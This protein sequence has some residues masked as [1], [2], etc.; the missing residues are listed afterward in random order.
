MT[1]EDKAEMLSW[2]MAAFVIMVGFLL[3]IGL[4]IFIEIKQEGVPDNTRFGYAIK[5]NQKEDG[6][7]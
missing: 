1:D 2:I 6:K 4:M 7:G 5:L 3:L